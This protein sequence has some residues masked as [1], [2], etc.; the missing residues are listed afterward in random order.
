M[1]QTIKE[2][3]GKTYLCTE[4]S[5]VDKLIQDLFKNAQEYEILLLE[6]QELE[7]TI[8]EQEKAINS[9]EYTAE[10]DVINQ[11]DESGKEINTNEAKRKLAKLDILSRNDIYREALKSCNNNKNAVKLKQNRIKTI[12]FQTGIYKRILEYRARND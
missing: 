1:N 2:L 9:I 7:N 11:K 3:D 5:Q 8:D 10:Y 12:E 4:L 6:V